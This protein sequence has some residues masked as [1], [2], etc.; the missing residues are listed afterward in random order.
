MEKLKLENDLMK[1]SIEKIELK[2]DALKAENA[3][4]KSENDLMKSSIDS[5]RHRVDKV[6]QK[7]I[8]SDL[9]VKTPKDPGIPLFS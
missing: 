1:S 5:C 2:V 7:S 3:S 8:G 9:L 4:L 6:E